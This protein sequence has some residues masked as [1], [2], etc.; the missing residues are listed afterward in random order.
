VNAT[1][2]GSS[3]PAGGFFSRLEERVRANRSL[4]CVGIDPPLHSVSDGELLSFARR[5]LESTHEVACVYKPNAAFFEARGPR[6]ME[7]L[8]DIIDTIH[9]AGFPVILDAKRGDISSTADAY[10]KAAFDVLNADAITINP[11]LG[12]DGVESFTARADRGVFVLCHTSNPGARD[13]QELVVEG[14]PL[15]E[16]IARL[17]VSWN[18]NGNVGLVTGATYPEVLSR[19]RQAAPDMWLLLPGVGSQGGDLEASLKAGLT[20]RGDGVIVNVSR[21]ISGAADPRK[22]ALEYR[23]RINNARETR[24]TRT[25]KMH[26]SGPG[27]TSPRGPISESLIDSLALGLHK[28]GAVKLGEFTLKSGMTSP[29]YIDLRLLV[30]DPGLM[31]LVA[32]AMAGLLYGL[33]FDR[34]AAIP[35]GGLPIGVAVSLATGKPMIYPRKE[36][37]EHGTKNAIE[38][39]FDSGET[40]VVLDDLIT[41]GGS[42]IEAMEPL[43]RAGLKVSDIVV[44]IDREQGGAKELAGRGIALH[45][46]F[47][48]S[49]LL[50]SLCRMGVITESTRQA[51]RSTLGI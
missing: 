39:R 48:L 16:R 13:L 42:K 19:V 36:V 33:R 49:E 32:R 5:I 8:K 37:K 18:R 12:S 29:I 41:T 34:I 17:A 14:V 46:V 25:G 1:V 30:S 40:V 3:P 21:G 22:A 6:G 24:A 27:E 4:L 38:G 15:Y 35:Y 10:A 23:D 28:V 20:G 47:T 7:S 11:L 2:K 31:S 9:S 43:A 26:V 51:V 50:L 44:L 45:A